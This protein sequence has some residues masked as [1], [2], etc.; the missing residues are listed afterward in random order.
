M[1]G[2]L[3][4]CVL[5]FS[6]FVLQNG[7]DVTW[8]CW[9]IGWSHTH[10]HT[11]N[12]TYWGSTLPKNTTKRNMSS[13]VCALSEIKILSVALLSQSKNLSV[14]W[15]SWALNLL[16]SMSW[17][18]GMPEPLPETR[19][20]TNWKPR[21]RIQNEKH[22]EFSTCRSRAYY[23]SAGQKREKTDENSGHYVI[24]LNLSGCW[25]IWVITNE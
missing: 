21:N 12:T 7:V 19:A 24:V 11:H 13:A 18:S 1:K 9:K 20:L 16:D 14:A 17:L 2:V 10:T 25:E 4:A 8:C 5:L 15:L 23:V 22:K 3:K 6:I